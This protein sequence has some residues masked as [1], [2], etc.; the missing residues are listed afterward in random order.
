MSTE[1]PVVGA[2]EAGGTKFRVAIGSSQLLLADATI[3]TTT[4]AETVAASIEF[5]RESKHRVEAIGLASFGPLDL[6]PHSPSYGSITTTPKPGWS[7]TPLLE[8]VRGSFDV[9]VAIDTDVGGAALGERTWGAARGLESFVYLTVGTGI[10]GGLFAGGRTHHGLG[11]PEMGHVVVAQEQ[12]D[13]FEGICPFHGSCIEGMASGPALRARWNHPVVDLLDRREVWDLEA[14]Y[15][16]QA[17]RS[18][19]YITAP[20][21]IIIGGGVMRQQGLLQLVR[22]KLGVELAGY[23]PS[24]L[25]DSDLEDYLVA[26]E[27]GQDAGLFGAMVLAQQSLAT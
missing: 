25:V 26:P 3:P 1:P 19:T 16:A 12:D 23:G 27:L 14:R 22:T 7:D 20:E 18:I 15:L 9:K 2:I 5:L 21:R 13:S 11:H 17:L 6:N 4:P 8:M 10:G 24:E